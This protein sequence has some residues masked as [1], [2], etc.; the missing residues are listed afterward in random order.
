MCFDIIIGTRRRGARNSC[1]LSLFVGP[2]NP[3]S[4]ALLRFNDKIASQ[5]HLQKK[6][7]I[8]SRTDRNGLSLKASL[9]S[10]ARN[11]GVECKRM[12]FFSPHNI[13]TKFLI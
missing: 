7:K 1:W 4:S 10:L 9:A 8:F 13:I 6:I 12:F 5:K 3:R 2:K 11:L